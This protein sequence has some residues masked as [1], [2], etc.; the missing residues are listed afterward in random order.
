VIARE[1]QISNPV[2]PFKPSTTRTKREFALPLF[3]ALREMATT[4]LPAYE[5]DYHVIPSPVITFLQT[6]FEQPSTDSF[7]YELMVRHYLIAAQPVMLQFVTHPST[8]RTAA[9]HNDLVCVA[10]LIKAKELSADSINFC[11]MLIA[12]TFDIYQGTFSQVISAN[13]WGK[14]KSAD[15]V[16]NGLFRKE[17]GLF[18]QLNPY[19]LKVLG[20]G[21][22]RR[23]FDGAPPS[24]LPTLTKW[25]QENGID[26]D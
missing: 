23:A 4:F 1:W 7:I 3:H 8:Q 12:E 26:L 19:S 18:R 16:I 24:A 9:L 20:S 11:D 5:V 25:G 17:M 13:Y 21:M 15:D 22:L 2:P 14:T 6:A 10:D